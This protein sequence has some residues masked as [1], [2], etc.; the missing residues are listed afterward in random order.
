MGLLP[1]SAPWSGAAE[2][3]EHADHADHAHHVD[4]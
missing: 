4:I 3:A 1:W 2:H